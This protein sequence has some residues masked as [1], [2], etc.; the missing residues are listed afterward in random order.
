MS[1]QPVTFRI[2]VR[3]YKVEEE[4]P[5]YQA[6]KRMGLDLTMEKKL[7][8]EQAAVDRGVVV[9]FGPTAFVEF[10]CDN[11]LKVGDEIVYAKHAGKEVEDLET[12]EKLVVINDGDV[13]A[14][15]KKEA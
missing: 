13:V 12:G 9:S 15:L 2:V 10:G 7:S 6:A 3:P 14:I 4:D 5:A 1:I 8:R 11:P